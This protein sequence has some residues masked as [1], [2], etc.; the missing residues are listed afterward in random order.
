IG[1]KVTLQSG[2]YP[3]KQDWEF[4]VDG[5]YE[6]RAKS[7]DRSTMFFH[8]KYLNDNIA[9][10]RQDQ[11][12]WIVSRVDDPNKTADIGAQLDKVFEEKEVPTLSQDEH[13]FQTSFM[14]GI[15]A[16]LTSIDIVS[17]V[18]LLIMMLVLGNTIAMGVRE[19]TNEYGVLKALGF[20]NA[21]ISMFIVSESMIIALA[22]AALGIGVA[23]PFI[24]KG[25]G[26]WLEE[27]M[28][29]F[30]PWFRIDPK[31]TVTAA[32]IALLLGAVAA[33]VPAVQASRLRVVDALRRVA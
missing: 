8:W 3:D 20:S 4:K 31:V 30:F 22:G 23:Y 21:H 27:N 1:S 26:R 17:V 5:I 24:E 15:S 14:A 33:I 32:V 25:F 9:A 10:A 6:P 16:V 19:R 13:T 18:I 12:G 7:A 28:G 11:V 2:I 29:A